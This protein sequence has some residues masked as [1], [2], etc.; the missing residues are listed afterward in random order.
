MRWND[1]QIA[2]LRRQVELAYCVEP[3]PAGPLTEMCNDAGVDAHFR[4]RRWPDC[5]EPAVLRGMPLPFLLPKAFRYYLP[6]Y[7]MAELAD[8]EEA[9]TVCSSIVCRFARPQQPPQ[10]QGFSDAE[11]LVV[12]S[13]LQYDAESYEDPTGFVALAEVGRDLERRSVPTLGGLLDTFVRKALAHYTEILRAVERRGEGLDGFKAE[14]LAGILVTDLDAERDAAEWYPRLEG[15][16]R[17]ADSGSALA[18]HNR[19]T[20]SM[21]DLPAAPRDLAL[22]HHYYCRARELQ[23][24]PARPRVDC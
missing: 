10:H 1:S 9:D 11:L 24:P 17:A 8:P 16:E 14:A 13:F 21:V 18:A 19:G 4:G 22:A 6:A 23:Y 5:V 20:L 7:M 12:F 15:L 2:D 3:V